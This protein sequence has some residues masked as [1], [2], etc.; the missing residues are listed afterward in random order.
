MS[1]DIIEVT[2]DTW[3]AEVMNSDLPTLVDFWAPWCGPCRMLAPTLKAIQADRTDIKVVK[4]NIDQESSVASKF[5]IMNIPFMML[6]KD[7]ET[8]GTL[9]GNQSRQKIESFLQ[10]HI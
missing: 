2:T 3:E 5:R 7:G 4:L 9:M 8:T 10:T 6:F 1:G